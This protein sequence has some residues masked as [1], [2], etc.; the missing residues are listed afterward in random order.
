M[1]KVGFPKV[2]W[3]ETGKTS[4]LSVL[5]GKFDHFLITIDTP[6]RLRGWPFINIG[7][8]EWMWTVGITFTARQSI[9]ALHLSKYK[10][11]TDIQ[12]WHPIAI[13]SPLK[14]KWGNSVSRPT[15]VLYNSLGY[16]HCISSLHRH[17]GP[18]MHREWHRWHRKEKGMEEGSKNT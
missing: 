5:C 11:A 6:R 9:F 18:L 10:R 4:G 17:Q 1:T 2:D 12:K 15:N 3:S 13:I 14:G 16:V 8:L 7:P